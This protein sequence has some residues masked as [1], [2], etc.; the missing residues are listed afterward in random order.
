[1]TIS[2]ARKILGEK[3]VFMKDETIQIII[4]MLDKIAEVAV[5]EYLVAHKQSNS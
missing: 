1:M 3:S 2:D 4:T 5:N